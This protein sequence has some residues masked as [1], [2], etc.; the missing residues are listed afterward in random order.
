MRI[1]L[2]N[3]MSDQDEPVDINDM[4]LKLSISSERRIYDKLTGLPSSDLTRDEIDIL[5]PQVYERMGQKAKKEN[6][7]LFLKVHDAFYYTNN[8]RPLFPKKACQNALYIIRNPLDVAVSYSFHKGDKNFDSMVS[9]MA[10]PK[11]QMAGEGFIQL[12]QRLTDWSNHV[13]SWTSQTEFPIKVIRYED[14]LKDTINVFSNVLAFLKIENAEDIHQIKKAVRFSAFNT[15]KEKESQ[16][17]FGES[18]TKTKRFFRSGTA[19]DWKN[20]L[21]KAQVDSLIDKHKLVMKK[22]GYLAE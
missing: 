8:G 19:N 17:G 9:H 7:R 5:R 15:L 18:G 6:K 16:L 22:F 10:D 4:Q 21:S 20:H 2:S 1:L 14:L 12:H 11:A 3:F 13:E